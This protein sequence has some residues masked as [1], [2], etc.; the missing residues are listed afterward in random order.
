[1]STNTGDILNNIINK[2]RETIEKLNTK[3]IHMDG[4]YSNSNNLLQERDHIIASQKIN[5]TFLTE[6]LNKLELENESLKKE[7]DELK[8]KAS[9]SRKS[10]IGEP[11]TFSASQL[12]K[13]LIPRINEIISDERAIRNTLDNMDRR[14]PTPTPDSTKNK[15]PQLKHYEN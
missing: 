7:N 8:R 5:I 13:S 4:A 3:I 6:R 12:P 9:G 11:L 10:S 2:Q 15:L 14:S 1:M